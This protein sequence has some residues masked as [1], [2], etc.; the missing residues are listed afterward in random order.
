MNTNSAVAGSFHEQAI[1][2]QQ[3]NFKKLRID[4]GGITI[5]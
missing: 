4:R 2:Y 5:V 3:F 1:N